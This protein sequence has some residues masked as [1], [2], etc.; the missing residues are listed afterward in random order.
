MHENRELLEG[1]RMIVVKLDVGRVTSN[2][3]M[4]GSL[5]TIISKSDAVVITEGLLV[6]P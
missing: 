1:I 6:A 2:G 3:S 5:C 4:G